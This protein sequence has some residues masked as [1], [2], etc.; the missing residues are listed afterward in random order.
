M[1][2]LIRICI[3]LLVFIPLVGLPA[4]AASSA[5]IDRQALVTRHNP[6]LH[7]L[8]VDSPFTVGNGGFAFGADITGLQTFA[9][10]YHR[11]GIPVETQSRWCWVSDPNTNNYTLAD[12]GREF[13]RADGRVLSYPTR[14]SSPAGDWLRKNPRSHPLGQISLDF[15]KADGSALV[16]EDIQNPEQKLDLWRGVMTSGYEIEG[17]PV[18]VTTVCHPER[19]LIAVRIES[20]L[21]NGGK[22]GVRIAFPRGHNLSIKNTPPLDWSH[23]ASHATKVASERRRSAL[24]ERNVSGTRYDVKLTWAGDAQFEQIEPHQFRLTADRS[25]RGEEADTSATEDSDSSRRRL[26]VLEFTVGFYPEGKSPIRA[27]DI[28]STLSASARHW[29]EFWESGAAVDFSGSTDPRANQIEERIIL[30]RY[31]MAAQMAG[32][33]PPQESG[34]TCNTWYGKHHTEMIWWHAAHFPL[35][36]NDELLAK[37]LEWYQSQLPAARE[38]A[39]SRGL[40]GARWAKMTGYEMRESPGG[41]PLIVWNQPHMVY[42]CELLYRNNPSRATLRKYRELVLETAD[43]L[44]FM[45]HFDDEKGHYVLGPPLWI[46]QEIYDQATS[47]NPSFELAYWQWALETAQTWRERLGMQRDE[48][49]D[50]VINNLTPVPQKDGKYVALGSHPDT[51]DNVDSRHDHP[52]M[53]APLGIL[54]GTGVERETMERTLDAVLETWDWETKIWGWDYPMIAMTAARLGRPETAVDILLREGP[55]N[56]Y[57]PNGHCPQRSDEKMPPNPPPGARK[58]EIA[59]YLPANGAFL[60]A[61]ALMIA[62]WDGATN[63]TPG[64]PD[65]G[66]WKVRWEGLKP[67]P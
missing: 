9:E 34:L 13:T 24:L 57:L 27:P 32:D 49:W 8:N 46:A 39:Q 56:V 43:C 66:T 50:H 6:V 62:G 15:T 33:V 35:W 22:L 1:K 30:S 19:D 10:H 3:A 5:P 7:E 67:L 36:G 2:D 51:W 25:R 64:I 53:L 20:S 31:L 59:V 60:S 12:A 41:N 29:K 63:A 47:Q 16:P 21:L 37:N 52:T 55:N 40:K 23:P 38:L 61:V 18:V 58:R 11:W 28:E 48:K 54:P 26:Q 14:Q 44:A 4:Q 45:V 42:L 17:T 65:D